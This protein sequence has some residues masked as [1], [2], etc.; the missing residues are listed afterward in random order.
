MQMRRNRFGG[1]SRP[2]VMMKMTFGWFRSLGN[3]SHN[4]LSAMTK[5]SGYISFEC[6]TKLILALVS[7]IQKTL[8][9]NE[10]TISRKRWSADLWVVQRKAAGS[11][12]ILIIFNAMT[13][14][15]NWFYFVGWMSRERHWCI[16]PDV[17]KALHSPSIHFSMEKSWKKKMD[18]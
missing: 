6:R 3:N 17:T 15:W 16:H 4:S 12:M 11:Q 2:K 7:L 10:C 18:G 8:L 5:L 14:A 13:S 1:N 9:E